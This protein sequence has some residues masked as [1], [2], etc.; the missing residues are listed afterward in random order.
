[1]IPEVL[2]DAESRM[3]KAVEAT[4]RELATLRTGRANPALVEHLRVE[5]YGQPTPLMQLATITVPEARLLTIQPWDRGAM[6]AIEKAIRTSDLGLNPSNDGTLIRLNIP[7]LTEERRREMVKLVHK[8]T[9][10]GRVAVRNVRRDALEHLRGLLKEKLVSEDDERR[11]AEQLQR[12]TDR[13]IAEVE[14]LGMA[15]EGEVLEV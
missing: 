9:E 13:Y 15:K 10:E 4:Q 6:A 7:T 2:R 12:V 1:M 11:A 3:A 5:Y 14:K 8:R